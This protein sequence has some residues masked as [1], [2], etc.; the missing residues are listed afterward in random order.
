MHKRD[1]LVKQFEEF[2]RVMGVIL[3]LR[4]ENKFSELSELLSESVKKYTP[5]EIDYVESMKD[6]I[7]IDILTQEKKL[8]D[9]Q[10]KMLGDLLFEKGNYY[11]ATHTTEIESNN[12]YKKSLVIYLFLKEHATLTYSLDMH[13]KLEI[14]EKMKL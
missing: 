3:G 5:T 11:S 13:Y 7:L 12:C 9:E 8:T 1:Y 2:G 10:L 6:E 4:K 14:L